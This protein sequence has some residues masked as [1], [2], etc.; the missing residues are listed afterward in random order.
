V[1]KVVS[2]KTVPIRVRLV[3]D[4]EIPYAH[5]RQVYSGSFIKLSAVLKYEHEY[6]HHGIAPISSSWNCTQARVLRLS[7]PSKQELAATHGIASNFVMTTRT[8]R[9]NLANDNHASF[10]TAFNSTSVYGTAEKD[11]DAVVTV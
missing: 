9:N 2:K 10:F 3:T 5:Q 1:S 11:G 8:M 7:L 6:F 4:I